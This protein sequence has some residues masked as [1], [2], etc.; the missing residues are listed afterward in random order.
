MAVPPIH[1]M[2][3]LNPW[4]STHEW[5]S[6][7]KFVED[8]HEKHG[9]E[10]A[11]RL[12]I[13]WAN[14]HFLGC[15]YQPNT[16]A[17]VMS[18]P[19]PDREALQ[20]R[21]RAR[22]RLQSDDHTDG[23]PMKRP[24]LNG[25]P[26]RACSDSTSAPGDRAG[27]ATQV[28]ALI[29]SVRHS[30]ESCQT[31]S[32]Q[33]DSAAATLSP[34]LHPLLRKVG[35]CVC[36]CEK[37]IVADRSQNPLGALEKTLSV[38]GRSDRQFSYSWDFPE[39]ARFSGPGGMTYKCQLLLNGDLVAEEEQTSKRNIKGLLAARI[40]NQMA[41]YRASRGKACPRLGMKVGQVTPEELCGAKRVFSEPAIPES[42]K[43]SQLLRKMGWT[44]SEGLGREGRGINEPVSMGIL[45][46][47]RLGLGAGGDVN[48]IDLV[49]IRERL[50]EFIWSDEMELSFPN[51]LNSEERAQVHRLCTQFGLHHRSQGQGEGRHIVVSRKTNPYPVDLSQ[52]EE[53]ATCPINSAFF[54]P[55]VHKVYGNG[56]N[57]NY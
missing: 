18:Y 12:S 10:K 39:P 46:N 3:K 50:Q 7:V 28:A 23:G 32:Q 49:N 17:I 11:I 47:Q 16:E 33:L 22:K 1:E 51:T 37:C 35:D 56:S 2:V 8:N 54:A 45:D 27:Y 19:L 44:G 6:R 53:P 48:G 30:Q 14:I 38:Y 5:E 52:R 55:A 41:D 42:N 24:K 9:L 15:R 25:S 21:A 20:S 40:L 57:Y 34:P 36:V 4:E 31:S 43:G 29:S 26:P 13:L